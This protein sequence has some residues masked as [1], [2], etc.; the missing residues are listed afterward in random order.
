MKT[1]QKVRR[2]LITVM[3]ALLPITLYYMSPVLSLQGAASGIIGGSVIVFCLQFAGSLFLGRLFCGWACPAGGA[4]EL[5][6]GLRRRPVGR[7]AGWSKWIIWV[8]WV[9]TLV[10]LVLRAGGVRRLDLFY[11]TRHGVSV[12]DLPGAIAYA[13]VVLV[14]LTLALALGRRGGC[15][16]LCWMAPFMVV[17]RSIRNVLAWPSLRLKADASLCGGCGTCTRKC[18]MSIDVKERVETGRLEAADC[19]LCASCADTCPKGAIRYSF[20]S[21]R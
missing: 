20:S 3:F 17:G 11:L 8:P 9:L 12:T 21:G 18:P 16:V 13:S 4:Q 7:R 1:R 14:F 10:F 5:V 15:H 2:V 19:I 6:M